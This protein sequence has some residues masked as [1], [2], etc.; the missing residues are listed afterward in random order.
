MELEGAG[1]EPGPRPPTV[2]YSAGSSSP[3]QLREKASNRSRVQT[4]LSRRSQDPGRHS[5][6]SGHRSAVGEE[7]QLCKGSAGRA[8][9]TLPLAP[10]RLSLALQPPDHML[11]RGHWKDSCNCSTSTKSTGNKRK[12]TAPPRVW[13]LSQLTQC[14]GPSSWPGH[15]TLTCLPGE[16]VLLTPPRQ[17]L[18]LHEDVVKL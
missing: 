14:V 7:C 4:Q 12:V 16:G 11:Q 18:G 5:V 8:H 15:R 6:S 1:L 10:P 2:P 9:K 17:R 13:L 3:G